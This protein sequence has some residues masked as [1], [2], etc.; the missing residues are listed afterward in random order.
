RFQNLLRG[1][2]AFALLSAEAL[3][4][5]QHA[6]EERTLR[7][8]DVVTREGEAGDCAYLI[9]EGSVEVTAGSRS[10]PVVLATMKE[11]ELFGEGALFS[12]S[13]L[14]SATVTAASALRLFTIS[15]AA[16]CK[17]LTENPQARREFEAA[18]K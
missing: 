4:S 16:F 14:R 15:R 11:G 10:G 9:V 12:E 3:H 13:G 17:I 6:A 7:E 8:G 1:V 18:A 2:P 5:V